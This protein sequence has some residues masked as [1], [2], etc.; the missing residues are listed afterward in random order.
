MQH[1]TFIDG[2][3]EVNAGG[4]VQGLAVMPKYIGIKI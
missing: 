3:P 4:Q 2:G 1:V